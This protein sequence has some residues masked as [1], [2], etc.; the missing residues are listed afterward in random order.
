M[1]HPQS[2]TAYRSGLTVAQCFCCSRPSPSNL[3]ACFWCSPRERKIFWMVAL[4]SPPLICIMCGLRDST[5]KGPNK[6]SG[7]RKVKLIWWNGTGCDCNGCDNNKSLTFLNFLVLHWKPTCTCLHVQAQNFT[8]TNV[9]GHLAGLGRA[10]YCHLA[11]Q[12]K[13]EKNGEGA[14]LLSV[15]SPSVCWTLFQTLFA[16]WGDFSGF[17]LQQGIDGLDFVWTIQLAFHLLPTSTRFWS[18]CFMVACSH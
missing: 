11:E 6:D 3:W 10:S 5:T 12:V 14:T 16:L 13:E 9:A 4:T 2:G 1:A 8:C 7:R 15:S 17:N 18:T